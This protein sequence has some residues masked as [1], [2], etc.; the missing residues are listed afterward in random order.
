MEWGEI[1]HAR[2]KNRSTKRE[3][4]NELHPLHP[5]AIGII[6]QSTHNFK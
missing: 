3:I 4:T 1:V 2:E 5:N 6:R